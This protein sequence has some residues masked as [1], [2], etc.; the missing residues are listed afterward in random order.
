MNELKKCEESFEIEVFEMGFILDKIFGTFENP[1]INQD[2]KLAYSLFK[3]GWRSSVQR[4]G[5]VFAPAEMSWQDADKISSEHWCKYQRSHEV[6]NQGHNATA[7]SIE[8]AR[9][10][11]CKNK[12]HQLMEEYKTMIEA[13]E[14]SHD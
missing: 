3:K 1:Y 2:T 12:A 9:L 5:F 13:Q 10:T 14:Q 4:K 8:L 11:W 6:Q 7:T